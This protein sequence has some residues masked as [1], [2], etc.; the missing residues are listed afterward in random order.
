[1]K[2]VQIHL[3]EELDEAAAAEAARRGMSKAA[4]IRAA[5]AKELES[6]YDLGAAWEAMTGWVEDGG[7]DDIDAAVYG[8]ARAS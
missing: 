4:L 8:P 7:M 5:L 2:R 1:M 3:E 6:G